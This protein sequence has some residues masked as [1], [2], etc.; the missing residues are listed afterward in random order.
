M[1]PLEAAEGLAAAGALAVACVAALGALS[2]ILTCWAEL[3]APKRGRRLKL[4]RARVHAVVR[5][6]GPAVL[7]LHGASASSRDFQVA[8]APRLKEGFR[9]VLLDRPGLGY[10]SRPKGAERLET[11]AALAA[12]A[13]ERLEAGPAIVV[14][15]SFGAAVAL[16]LAL[17]R[18]EL[19]RGLVLIAPASHP[20]PGPNAWHARLAARPLAG[21]LFCRFAVPLFGPLAAPAAVAATFRPARPPKGYIAKSGLNLLFRPGSFRANARDIVASRAEF[22]EQAPRYGEI[23]AYCLILTAD[24]DTVTSPRR[25]ARALYA[26]LPRAELIVLPGAGHAPHQVR[27]ETVVAAVRRLDALE[28]RPRAR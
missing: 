19:V 1:I 8:V 6:E 11:Q 13:L 26:E 18:P 21:R 23:Q 22:A 7:F 10:S 9:L 4:G 25:H 17:D 27:P 5:G 12:A 15:H 24:E 16:R 3:H 2:V 20:Y 28:A 14:A